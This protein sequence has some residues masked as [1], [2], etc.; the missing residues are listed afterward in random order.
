[1]KSLWYIWQLP[2]HILALCLMFYFKV[3]G[4]EVK[5]EKGN[6]LLNPELALSEF[7]YG[8]YNVKDFRNGVCLGE[9]IFLD[10]SVEP[11]FEKIPYTPLLHEH[12][13]RIQS[14]IL[15]PLYLL[16]VGLPS[17]IRNIYARYC[18]NKKRKSLK[19][20]TE[21]YYSQYPENWADNLMN[22]KR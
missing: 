19:D 8:F 16:L 5:Y 11:Y 3:T 20:I 17:I 2:Q 13:H 4:K 6:L 21:W 22:V 12:G 10:T 1:M 7:E 14:R 15:G 9:Y 18:L